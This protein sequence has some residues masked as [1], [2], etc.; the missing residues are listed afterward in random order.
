M[1]IRFFFGRAGGELENFDE[2][3]VA[4][5][6]LPPPPGETVKV[7]VDHPDLANCELI[8]RAKLCA[9]VTFY[10]EFCCKSCTEA[11]QL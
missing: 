10:A 1:T 2:G 7:C 8:V 6:V 4:L 3:K 5:H 11:G 9:K